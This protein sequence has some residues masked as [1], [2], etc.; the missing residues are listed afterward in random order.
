MLSEPLGVGAFFYCRQGDMATEDL[1]DMLDQVNA[2]ITAILTR[3]QSVTLN[4]QTYSRANISELRELRKDLRIEIGQA[5]RGGIR[6]RRIVT[7]E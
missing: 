3:G 1:T 4:G 7:F 2:A 6:S 5:K